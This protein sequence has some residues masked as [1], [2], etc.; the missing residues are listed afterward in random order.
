[1]MESKKTGTRGY[2]VRRLIHHREKVA[3]A[4]GLVVVALFLVFSIFAESISP[5]NPNAITS[6][7]L[8]PPSGEHWMG[9]DIVGRDVFSRTVFGTRASMYVAFLAVG[10]ASSLG[11]VLGIT[12]GYLSGRSLELLDRAISVIMDTLYSFPLFILAAIMAAM[13]GRSTFN[14]AIAAAVVSIPSYFRVVRS[15]TLTVKE[16]PF[17][18]AERAVGAG[19][20]RIVFRHILPYCLPSIAAVMS[21]GA[22]EAILTIG[23]L[24]FLGLGIPPPTPEWGGDLNLGRQVTLLGSWWPTLFPGLM[25]FLAILSFNVIGES[26][27]LILRQSK[28]AQG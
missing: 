7:I 13:L 26:I 2:Y 15:I 5:Y 21:M 3:M 10:L 28:K 16:L 17:I 19:T 18:E 27:E 22:A 12:S 20:R 9:T 11:S 4:I 1:M 25:I 14:I 23:G 24:G 8:S 6:D